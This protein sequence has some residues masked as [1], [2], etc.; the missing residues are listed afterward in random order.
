M[1]PTMQV[2]SS[3]L[4]EKTLNFPFQNMASTYL[5]KAEICRKSVE[6][7][8]LLFRLGGCSGRGEK[9]FAGRS[10]RRRWTVFGRPGHAGRVSFVS[11]S[12]CPAT[13]TEGPPSCPATVQS[14]PDRC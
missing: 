5:E 3:T 11:G 2:I 6:L 8:L 4:L 7:I 10:D 14:S 9:T 13:S 12:S 1:A